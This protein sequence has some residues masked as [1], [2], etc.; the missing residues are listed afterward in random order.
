MTDILNENLDIGKLAHT[1]CCF[2]YNKNN[3]YTTHNSDQ[4]DFTVLSPNVEQQEHLINQLFNTD[5]KFLYRNGDDYVFKSERSVDVKL[6]TN[7]NNNNAFITYKLSDLVLHGKT[8]GILLN[9]LNFRLTIGTLRPFI[10]TQSILTPWLD[11]K[12]SDIILC[13][14]S[15]HFYK[16]KVLREVMYEINKKDIIQQVQNTM[17]AICKVYPNFKHNNLTVD[18]V[19]VYYKKDGSYEAKITGFDFAKLNDKGNKRKDMDIFKESFTK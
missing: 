4:S 18:T 17:N 6:T 19:H 15:E 7:I 12:D 2:L 16:K 8:K 5:I 1:L 10:N 9:I 11:K 14:V 3:K 13:T